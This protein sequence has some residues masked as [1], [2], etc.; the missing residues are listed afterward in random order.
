MTFLDF[1]QG[2]TPITVILLLAGIGLMILEMIT[3][4]FGLA[5]ISSICCLVLSIVLRARV[6][7]SA[8]VWMTALVLLILGVLLIVF[9]RSI[10]KGSISRS[11]IVLNDSIQ[12]NASYIS[13]SDLGYYLGKA[14]CTLSALR[15]TGT[16][17]VEGVRLNVTSSGDFIPTGTPIRVVKVEGLNL[18]VAPT[19]SEERTAPE[20]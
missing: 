4:G 10:T 2:F 9:F 8:A 11:P 17:E 13:S 1:L 7:F 15:P 6:S 12:G 5:G 14:G 19:A 16:A 18:I 3:P 20:A